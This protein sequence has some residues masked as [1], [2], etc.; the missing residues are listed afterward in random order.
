MLYV[1]HY[2][3]HRKIPVYLYNILIY[4]EKMQS[5]EQGVQRAT[6]TKKKDKQSGNSGKI[7]LKFGNNREKS[8]QNWGKEGNIGKAKK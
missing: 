4:L 7:R 3:P 2:I 6:L 5:Q 8:G 1:Y